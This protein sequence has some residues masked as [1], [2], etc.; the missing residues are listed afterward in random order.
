MTD[1]ATKRTIVS[2]GKSAVL[3]ELHAIVLT[4]DQ[5]SDVLDD[6]VFLTELTPTDVSVTNL[7]IGELEKNEGGKHNITT[8]TD[9]NSVVEKKN[10]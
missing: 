1:N 8:T 10:K 9:N 4:L 5:I 6:L 3:T 2:S 7:A